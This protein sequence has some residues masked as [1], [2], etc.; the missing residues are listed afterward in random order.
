V[1]IYAAGIVCWREQGGKLEVA[2]VHREQYKDWGFPKGKLD[3]GEQ[4]PQTAV[5]EVL[6]EAGFKVRLGRKLG[7]IKYQVGEG[8]DKEVHYWASKVTAKAMAKQKFASN[9]EIAK[10]EWI[11]AKEAVQLLSY[12]HDKNLMEQ[13][14]QLHKAKELETRALII[15]RHA[16]ATLRSDWKGEEAK[17]TLLPEGKKQAKAL[18][19][20]IAAYGPKRLITSPWVRCHDTIA[21]YAETRKQKLIERHQLTELGNKKRPARTQDVV[22]DLLG[23]SNS[24]LISAHRPALPSILATFAAVAPKDL[25]KE[26]EAGSTLSPAE[27]LVLRITL[28]SK[29]KV[30]GVERCGLNDL[31]N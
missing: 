1:T 19:P 26:I 22:K 12:E 16:K 11:A 20:L 8:L 14:I 15:L 25:R 23:T 24:G 31:A 21:P 6:E 30:V 4:L 28:S 2:L 29:P 13:V 10:V 3:P 27:F 18:V 9:Q 7:V 17:R 5:R